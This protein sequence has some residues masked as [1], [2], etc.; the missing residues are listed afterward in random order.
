[1]VAYDFA[2]MD[3][4]RWKRNFARIFYFLINVLDFVLVSSQ[5]ITLI[6]PQSQQFERFCF[7][8]GA[9]MLAASAVY[10]NAALF[11]NR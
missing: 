5:F 9:R 11:V 1:M 8:S 10:E 6:S 7:L 4:I 3:S 2:V